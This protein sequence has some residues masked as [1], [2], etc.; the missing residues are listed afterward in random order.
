MKEDKFEEKKESKEKNKKIFY[1]IDEENLRCVD[2][3]KEYPTKISINHGVIICESCSKEHEL[4]GPSISFLKN[5]DE[6]LDDYLLTFILMG[7]N[8]KFKRFLEKE[9]IDNKKSIKLKYMTKGVDFYRKNLKAKVDGKKEIEKT[10]KDANEIIQN[11]YKN[12]EPEFIKYINKDLKILLYPDK[13]PR[14]N[15]ERMPI[16]NIVTQDTLGYSFD[17]NKEYAYINSNVPLLTGFYTAH[18]NHYPIRIKPDDIWLLIVQAFSNHVNANSEELRNYFVN[19]NGKKT[20]TVT[21]NGVFRIEN[22]NKKILEDFSVQINN[23]M[24]EYLGK[25]IL[26][27]LTPDFTT[28]TYDSKIISKISIMGAFKKYFDYRMALA[29]CGNPYIILEG[30]VEDYKK[31]KNKAL[32]LSKFKFEWYINRIIPHIQKMIEAKESSIDKEYFQNFIQKKE[33][34][35]IKRGSSG[36]G[37]KEVKVDGIC[38]W[39]LNFFAYLNKEDYNGKIKRFTENS[40]KIKNFKDLANQMLIVPFEIYEEI[41]KKTYS[42]KYKVGFLGCDQNEEKEVFP[43]QG[44]IV[45]P[46]SKEDRESIL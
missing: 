11:D 20:L 43:I 3:G 26:D 27:I 2:C 44:W 23:Q 42:M 19:F 40:I 41:T 39:I 7:M 33:M 31:I 8:T 17:I 18:V 15:F 46:S 4:L 45:S 24:I 21:Y 10:Y 36:I 12:I 5:I 28:T 37:Y 13:K 14:Y 16:K 30:S 22:V 34:T 1:L 35:E 29:A 6:N 32:K 9:K 25:E 38:G